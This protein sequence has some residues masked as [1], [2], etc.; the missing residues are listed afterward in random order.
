MIARR[1]RIGIDRAP[2]YDQAELARILG[3]APKRARASV[4]RLVAAGLLQWSEEAIGFPAGLVEMGE[5]GDGVVAD[6]IG[7]GRGNLAIP[8]RVLRVLVR[9]GRPALIATALGAL[10][11]CLSRRQ[12]GFDGRGRVKASWVARAFGVDARAVK[13]ARSELVALGWLAPE[14]SA[15]AALNRWGRAY[16]IDLGWSPTRPVGGAQLPPPRAHSGAQSLPPDLHQDPLPGLRKNQDP[17]SCGPAGFEDGG[18]KACEAARS[19][20][21]ESARPSAE[22]SRLVAAGELA[23]P[24]LEDVRPE[25]LADADR[26][27][28]LHRQAAARGLVGMSE[29]D[30]L[31]F[32]AAAEHAR[33]VGLRNPCGLFARIVG[34]GWWHFATLSEEERAARRL[35][36]HRGAGKPGRSAGPC[37]LDR[38]P[39][40]LDA[41]LGRLGIGGEPPGRSASEPVGESGSG[42]PTRGAQVARGPSRGLRDAIGRSPGDPLATKGGEPGGPE[43]ASMLA[44]LARLIGGGS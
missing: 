21:A 31:K 7:S 29:A 28:E 3:I 13:A 6:S 10:L 23:P 27:M 35:R 43:E 2:I 34:R 20:T 22:R 41:V 32:A 24:R 19:E 9:G 39:V 36:E 17:A 42:G 8:R 38:G 37:G 44:R 33:S 40:G 26:L 14:S 1:G 30:R 15:Q 25:D 11:R 5:P 16:R 4:R 12:A 18:M